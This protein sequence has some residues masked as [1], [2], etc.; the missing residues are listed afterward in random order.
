MAKYSCV[1][2]WPCSGR[3]RDCDAAKGKADQ[4]S[5]GREL[6]KLETE[7]HQFSQGDSPIFAGKHQQLY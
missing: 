5:L 6:L 7:F 3:S 4:L 2:Q 1:K